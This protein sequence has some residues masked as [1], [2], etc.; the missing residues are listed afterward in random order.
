MDQDTAIGG[1]QGRFPSTQISLL[2]AAAKGLPGEALERVAALYWK[3]VYRFLRAKFH[4]DNE[5]AK[6][7]TQGFFAT[8]I[9]RGF[10][11]HFDPRRRD[12]H[13]EWKASLPGNHDAGFR[14]RRHRR[15]SDA[16]PRHGA[17]SQPSAMTLSVSPAALRDGR[18]GRGRAPFRYGCPGGTRHH[19]CGKAGSRPKL[20]RPRRSPR[21]PLR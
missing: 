7:L 21:R 20:H 14:C 13:R 9:E 11:T 10:F 18:P 19:G 5:D 16:A 4:Y 8:A 15:L 3:P 6:D 17:D 1:P 2:E 12:G